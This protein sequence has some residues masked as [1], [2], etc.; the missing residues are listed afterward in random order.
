MRNRIRE[1]FRAKEL[2]HKESAKIPF[3][4]KI[5]ML[6]TLQKISNDIKSATGRKKEKAWKI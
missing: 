3:E 2:F 1:I 4:E 6:I 5:E